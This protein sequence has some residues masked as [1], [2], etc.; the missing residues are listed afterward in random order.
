M[1]LGGAGIIYLI[2]WSTPW[3]P[4]SSH[5]RLVEFAFGPSGIKSAII[6]SN[7]FPTVRNSLQATVRRDVGCEP[8]QFDGKFSSPSKKTTTTTLR[9]VQVTHALSHTTGNDDGKQLCSKQQLSAN[10]KQ[11]ANTALQLIFAPL[12]T[13]AGFWDDGRICGNP[14]VC[15]HRRKTG[16]R[17]RRLFCNKSSDYLAKRFC[18]QTY[19]FQFFYKSTRPAIPLYT[20]PK[21]G[22]NAFTLAAQKW[23]MVLFIRIISQQQQQP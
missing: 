20:S 18:Q 15:Q 4:V 10:G 9:R 1:R 5:C 17:R 19:T 12:T 3:K 13:A 8:F 7:F 14:A 22:N 21:K 6:I 16:C 11:L 23:M 2:S